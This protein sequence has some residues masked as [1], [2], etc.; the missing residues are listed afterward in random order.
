MAGRFLS[1]LKRRNVIR[2]GGVYL[3]TSWALF[4]I[5]KTIFET[6]GFPKWVPQLML[7]MLAL[8]LPIAMIIAWA[9][10]RGP[11]GAIR[12]TEALSEDGEPAPKF[13]WFDGALLAAIGAVLVISLLQVTGVFGGGARVPL[14]PFEDKSVAVLPFASFSTKPETEYFAD[15]LTEEVINSLA[16]VE[17]LKVA[18][19]TSAFYFK[20]R[21]EDLRE[22]GRKL[23]VA[24][25]VEGSVRHDGDRLRVTAQLI[26]VSDGFHLWSETFDRDMKDAFV[27]QT[28]IAE[29]VAEALKAELDTDDRR[30]ARRRDPEAYRLELTSRAQ[31]RNLGLTQLTAARDGF[32]RLIEMEPENPEGYAGFAQAAALLAQHHLQGDFMPTVRDA[33]AA[34]AK[35]LELDPANAN[36][37]IARGWVNR[38]RAIRA[39]CQS[40][41]GIATEAFKK[42]ADLEPRNPE[43]LSIYGADIAVSQPTQAITY[44]RRALAIDPLDRIAQSF[45]AEA[46]AATGDFAGAEQQYRTVVELFPDF[47]DPKQNLADVLI[48]QGKLDEAEPLLLAAAKPG[49][50]P[51]ADLQL[52]YLYLNLGMREDMNAVLDR[53]NSSKAAREVANAAKLI[54]QGRYRALYD[55]SLRLLNEPEPDPLWHAIGLS[56]AALSGDFDFARRQL[57][58]ILPELFEPEPVV[59]ASLGNDAA[60]AAWII[61]QTGDKGQSRRILE[62]LLRATEPKPGVWQSH[63]KRIA[64]VKAFV[65]LGEKERAL[66]ELRAAIDAGY[67]TLYDLDLF[68]RLDAYPMLAPLRSDARFQAMLR[69]VDADVARMRAE[70]LARRRGAAPAAPAAPA[71]QAAA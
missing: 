55:H 23:G 19:R 8:G 65:M 29:A 15:G 4:G 30:Q 16:K 68:L 32:Q 64:R 28:E 49:T 51:S 33:E 46:L 70:L 2:V 3:V 34:I 63:P 5:A 9:F 20:G 21:N 60:S 42:A 7:V 53:L 56:A 12:R 71:H 67:R 62:A 14:L 13:S 6:M 43:A 27:I 1:E 69:E 61:E 11:D 50:D 37:Y 39:S 66:A 52:A 44:L 59:S 45:L 18:G 48:V 57:L 17:E 38:I 26:K 58:I 41:E 25:V 47:I 22:I 24:H 36:A 40:C 31:L 35:A 10:E 54:T